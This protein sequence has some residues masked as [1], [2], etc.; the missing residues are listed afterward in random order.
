MTL[1]P[2]AIAAAQQRLGQQIRRT[3]LARSAVLSAL[4]DADLHLKFENLQF[5]AS[6]KERGALNRLLTM[7]ETQ[8]RGGIVAM[9]A[10]NHAQALAHHGERLGVPVTIVMPRSTPNAKVQQTRVFGTEVLLHG[11]C[12]AETLAFTKRL[13]DERQLTLVHP[14]DDESVIAGQGTLGLEMLEQMPDLDTLI[15]PVGGGGLIAGVAMAAKAIRPE[16]AIVGVQ[17]ERF[18]TAADLFNGRRAAP[19]R[20]GTIAEGIA[21]ETPG[22]ITMPIIRELVDRMATVAEHDIERAVF[23]LLE[24]EK[25]VTEGAGA[26]ALAAVFAEP[27]LAVG[28]T[29]LVLSGGNIDMMMLSSTVQRG[30]VRSKR[31]VRLSVEIPDM[32]GSLAALTALLGELDSN[33]VD[34]IHQR[35]FRASSVR[36]TLVELVL[37]MR[38]EEQAE[39]VVEVL[40]RAIHAQSPRRGDAFVAV[41]CGAIPEALLESE[42]FGHAK[43]AF[44]GARP[45]AS[46]GPLRRGRR[47]HPLPRRGR[48]ELPTRSPGEAAAGAPGGGGAPPGRVQVRGQIDVRVLAA[49]ARDL[50]ADVAA[51]GRF[52]EDLFYRLN[53]VRLEVPPLR[54]RRQGRSAAGR[55]FHCPLPGGTLGKPLRDHQRRRAGAAGRLSP[56]RAT[57]ASSRT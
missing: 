48:R 49:T 10:G 32:P 9:S 30:L 54:E 3:P 50:E 46:P 13:A 1:T 14:F 29:A 53:V 26:V 18:S 28:K 19:S 38:G 31:L 22:A 47:R 24:I 23:A 20:P 40:A 2:K 15:V 6:F 36:A 52:R 4:L 41:N 45:R 21:V 8:R 51:D 44:T 17:A 5:T 7:N 56:G 12:F 27:S 35:A 43:G 25:T 16:I 42:L 55:P 34:I 37:Q 33:I 11:S 39:A 57:C